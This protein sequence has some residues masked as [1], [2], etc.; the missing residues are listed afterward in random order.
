MSIESIKEIMDAFDPASVLPDLATLFGKLEVVCRI[1]VLVGPIALLIMGLAYLFLSP[2][3]ANHYFGYRCYFGM[4]SVQAW[5][6]TQR[7]SGMVLGVLGLVLLVVMFIVSGGFGSMEVMDMVWKAVTCLIWEAVLAA[8]AT[9]G[10]NLLAAF[11]YNSRGEPRHR[12]RKPQ[13]PEA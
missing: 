10:I 9:L 5:R 2:K 7:I 13:K 1:A 12:S 4:G 8:L 3:E 11:L 6:F